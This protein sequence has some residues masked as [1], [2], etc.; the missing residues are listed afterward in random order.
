[1][2]QKILKIVSSL[3]T[4]ALTV[5]LLF[6]LTNLMERKASDQKYEDFMKQKEDFDVLFMGTSH[7][8]NGIYPMELWHDYGI[9]SYNCGGHSNQFATTYWVMR[10][11]LEQTTPKLIVIDCLGLE[12][13]RKC[14]DKFSF[15][16]LSLDAFP[17]NATKVQA[18]WDLLDDPALEE[19]IS[20][21]KVRKSDEPR[22]KIGLLWDFSV[23]HSRW[24]E[25]GKS[26]FETPSLYEKGAKS[27]IKITRGVYNPIPE[28]EK[29][30]PGTVSDL[31]LRKMIEYCQER[32][33]EVMLTYVPFPASV[34]R[35]Q[36]AHYAADVAKEYNVK[37]VNCL[38]LNLLNF[39]TDCYDASSHLNPSGARKVTKYLGK[40]IMDNY[41][42]PDRREDTSYSYWNTDYDEYIRYVKNENLTK[43]KNLYDYMMLLSND[44]VEIHMDVRNKNLYQC[45]MFQRLMSNFDIQPE[46]LTE[47]ASSWVIK[48]C[49]KNVSTSSELE[50]PVEEEQNSI[51]FT[52]YREGKKIDAVTFYYSLDMKTLKAK[53]TS[54][55]R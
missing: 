27:R 9:V 36:A 14:S 19:D 18:I 29:I 45:E 24:A 15:V 38:D 53:T 50:E 28:D 47:E 32:G 4:I 25:L 1:M 10:N 23:Y 3:I 31:Y 21:G 13:N 17:L 54:T 30:E 22:T 46:Q 7:V 11:A 39:D 51:K 33:I 16:H 49:G 6:S 20:N 5:F 2:K 41:D 8:I 55:K 42:I 26:D 43:N 35:Q 37:Y 48:N 40:Y 34:K 12:E 44:D 52:V